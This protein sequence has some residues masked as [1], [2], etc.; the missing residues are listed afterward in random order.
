MKIVDYLIILSTWLLSS[1][2]FSY[3]DVNFK[4]LKEHNGVF[5]VQFGVIGLV[6]TKTIQMESILNSLPNVSVIE[7][8]KRGGE[9]SMKIKS[10]KKTSF[11]LYRSKFRSFGFEMDCRF[12]TFPTKELQ[13]QLEKNIKR[14]KNQK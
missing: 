8:I 1:Y 2:T 4:K 7:V 9:F 13:E 11:S 5:E 6:N 10:L 14:I 12:F 3:S